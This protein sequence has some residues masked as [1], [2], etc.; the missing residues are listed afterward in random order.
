MFPILPTEARDNIP[1]TPSLPVTTLFPQLIIL[2][3][4]IIHKEFMAP[5]NN[6]IDGGEKREETENKTKR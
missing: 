4:Q 3:R 2:Y 1:C 6:Q 5:F